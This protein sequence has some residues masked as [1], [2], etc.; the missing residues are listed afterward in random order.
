MTRLSA[1][2]VLHNKRYV[3]NLMKF[4]FP[5]K[6]EKQCLRSV[7]Q[8]S[9]YQTQNSRAFKSERVLV[10]R[11]NKRSWHYWKC[12]FSDI[13]TEQFGQ[14]SNMVYIVELTKEKYMVTF[15]IRDW[16]VRN[17][18]SEAV[19]RLEILLSILFS[20]RSLSFLLFDS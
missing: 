14:N 7:T 15:G 13:I 11:R 16:H 9:R 4:H 1:P 2:R 8:T 12:C 5:L 18:D 20:T 19:L 10:F 17:Y 3:K 6:F